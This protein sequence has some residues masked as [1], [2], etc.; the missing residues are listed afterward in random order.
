LWG[1]LN[2]PAERGFEQGDF[3]GC[4]VEQGVDD[5]VYLRFGGADLRAEPVHFGSIF[6]EVVFPFGA[7]FQGDIGAEGLF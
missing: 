3:I 5:G 4:Q 7:F 2:L 1:R 6:T